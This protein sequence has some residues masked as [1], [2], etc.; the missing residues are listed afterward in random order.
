M[1]DEW[2]LRVDLAAAFRL[3]AEFNWHE[4]V[5]N[6]FSAAV[7]ADGRRFLLNPRWKH[8]ATIR[9]SDLLLLDADDPETMRRPGAPDPS[10]WCI[11]GAVH[12]EVRQAR[13]LLHC[14]APYATAL[15][16][17]KDPMLKPIEQ[18]T[19]R[20]IGLVG[21]DQ[22]YGG[23]ADDEA[24]GKRIAAALGRH[25]ILLMGNH[26]L[27]VSA[28]TVAEAFEHLYYFERAARTM[29]LAYASGQP[30]NVMS[31]AV[32]SKTAADWRDYA[33]AAFAHFEQLKAMLD[34]KDKSYR[35]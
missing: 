29:L 1:S 20:F 11:H 16:T 12:R 22:E 27:S 17:L 21:L 26:G 24:E 19:A 32:A 34:A 31:D 33:D 5:A 3:A 23:I 2:S 4:S 9:A 25:P 10:A 15:A 18:N 13:V 7:S 28:P 30:L 8:F 14:H 6:H 35:D